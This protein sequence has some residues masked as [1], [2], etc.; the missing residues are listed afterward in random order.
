MSRAENCGQAD[1]TPGRGGHTWRILGTTS[2]AGLLMLAACGAAPTP[3][4]PSAQAVATQVVG[5][6]QTGATQVATTAAGAR[7]QVAGTVQ[8]GQTAV[9]PTVAAAETRVAGTVQVGS[10]QVA[11][12]VQTAQTAVATTIVAAQ[13]TV[14][15]AAT[16]IAPTIVAV[17]TQVASTVVAAQTQVAATFGPPAATAAAASPV[18][19]TAARISQNDPTVTITNTST[20]QANISGWTLVL[21][22]FGV[23][24]PVSTNLR[25]EPGAKV[26]IH[27][28]SGT[29][30]ATDV[31]TGEVPQALLNT[32][33][34]GTR[35]ALINLHG[36][37]ASIYQ[38][39]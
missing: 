17:Q 5:T 33:T 6:A 37:V 14:D 24:L 2:L 21:G 22:S 16:A 13:G 4:R 11:G 19:I 1:R 32:L 8:T 36:Q 20:S 23:V 30:T 25:I 39:P 7:T 18:Q 10:T 26:T 38:L 3:T 29:S 35:L 28:T 12:T 15:A 34:S 31:Y 9:A 27:L